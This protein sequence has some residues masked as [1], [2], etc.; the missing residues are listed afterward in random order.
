MKQKA[1][2][3]IAINIIPPRTP[4][5][6]GAARLVE[7]DVAVVACEEPVVSSVELPVGWVELEAVNEL[8]LVVA[9][10]VCSTEIVEEDADDE[11]GRGEDTVLTSAREESVFVSGG[12]LVVVSGGELVAVSGGE[13]VVAVVVSVTVRGGSAATFEVIVTGGGGAAVG[14]CAGV[15]AAEGVV[16][17][18]VS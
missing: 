13:S 7:L 6:M 1:P 5:T 12:E 4:P 10:D 15:D 11:P 8:K 16:A 17:G 3:N 2:T 18:S 9:G 14:V